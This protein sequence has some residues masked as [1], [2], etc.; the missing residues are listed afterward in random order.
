MAT[1]GVEGGVTRRR[2]PVSSVNATAGGTTEQSS[3][4][5]PETP[6][7]AAGAGAGAG[8]AMTAE[9]PSPS[10]GGGASP[11]GKPSVRRIERSLEEESEQW[12]ELIN[13]T[14]P[15]TV[16]MRCSRFHTSHHAPPTCSIGCALLFVFFGR[17]QASEPLPSWRLTCAK[18]HLCLATL[19]QP[20]TVQLLSS[21]SS[22]QHCSSM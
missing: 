16:H 10:M 1:S 22:T 2:T 18:L 15:H 20:S 4:M 17:L 6:Q 19:L 14:H 8:G 11:T 7:P 13:V 21:S 3:T 12:K 9:S 5:D